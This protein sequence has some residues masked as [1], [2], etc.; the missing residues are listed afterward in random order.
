MAHHAAASSRSSFKASNIENAALP[1]RK[2][3]PFNLVGRGVAGVE[4]MAEYLEDD[5]VY[6]GVLVMEVG[7]GSFKRNK[8]IFVHFNGEKHPK[9]LQRAKANKKKAT[10]QKLL[11]P[12]HAELTL[13][14]AK[15]CSIDYVFHKV[16]R[17]FAADSATKGTTTFEIGSLK[18]EYKNK[19]KEARKKARAQK[20]QLEKQRQRLLAQQ[21][22]EK[23]IMEEAKRKAEEE[24][25]LRK[26]AEEAERKRKEEEERKRIEDEEAEAQRLKLEQE[27]EA[28]R[29]KQEE[30]E[31][32]KE[33]QQAKK[34]KR[35][36][37]RK[38]DD[39]GDDKEWT[40]T[41]I[42]K[43]IHAQTSPMNWAVF[44]PSNT[45]IIPM[46][47]GHGG[48]NDLRAAL[49]PDQVQYGI[50]RLTFGEGRFRR[51][52]WVFVCWSPDSMTKVDS[53]K[54]RK[55]RMSDR[56]V[57]IGFKGW[58]QKSI[59]PY[60][61]EVLAEDYEYVTLEDWILRVRKTVVVDGEA[62][63]AD[64]FRKALEAEKAHFAEMKAKKEEEKR[65]KEE[66]ERKL[67]EAEESSSEEDVYDKDEAAKNRKKRKRKK[68]K[69]QEEEEDG[70]EDAYA[71]DDEGGKEEDAK[72]T[73]KEADKQEKK[74]EEPREGARDAQRLSVAQPK[75]RKSSIDP[76]TLK[77]W[78]VSAQLTYESVTLMK[79]PDSDLVWVLIEPRL[80]KGR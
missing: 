62:I 79:Q 11:S 44:K 80:R 39:W 18:E 4:E 72:E 20:E 6:F 10:A 60:G 47:F 41:R 37:R 7:S 28:K 22:N 30:E 52:H 23:K 63:D 43:C 58:M 48:L 24:E 68:K 8:T 40:G 45:D 14:N 12:Y 13:E 57:H 27:A 1:W 55:K 56:M 53:Q 50:M 9:P 15:Q 33:R 29:L 38:K 64:A 74:E 32:T 31:K 26:E 17:L 34:K 16:G 51:S 69:G 5:K 66:L 78:D 61:V 49:K 77:A 73:E 42:V 59:G 54:V 65:K 19:M 75:K 76:S 70:D 21:E 35:K 2:R 25:R 71:E 36:K 67:N 3:V 46:A